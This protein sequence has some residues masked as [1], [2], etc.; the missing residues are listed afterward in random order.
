MPEKRGIPLHAIIRILNIIIMV[1]LI[2]TKN[3]WKIIADAS[4]F[5]PEFDEYFEKRKKNRKQTV[6]IFQQNT[7]TLESKK[8]HYS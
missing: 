2:I 8:M 3:G 6:L 7:V 4:S 5:H 1:G